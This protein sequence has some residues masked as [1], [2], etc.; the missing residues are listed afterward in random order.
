MSE[1]FPVLILRAFAWLNFV[2]GAALALIFVTGG[3]SMMPSARDT[4]AITGAQV[5]IA[6]AAFL[7]GLMLWAFFMTVAL[8]ADCLLALRD[9]DIHVEVTQPRTLLPTGK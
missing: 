7:G 1:N 5:L 4:P 6:L 3:L 9:Q 8:M 2:G